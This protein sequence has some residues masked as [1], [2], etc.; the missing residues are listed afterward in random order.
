MQHR[1]VWLVVVA[2]CGGGSGAP[3]DAVLLPDAPL[4]TVIDAPLVTFVDA[5]PDSPPGG[6]CNALTQ[7][8]CSIGEKC[9]WISDQDN[10]PIGHVGCAPDP[11][12]SGI[13]IGSPCT[14]PPAGPM[15]YDNCVR[16]SVCLAGICKQICDLQNGAPTCDQNHACTRYADFFEVG[17]TAV[18]GVCDPGCDPLTQS[19]LAGASPLACGSVDPSMP[20]R[21]C[22]GY[23]NYSCSPAGMS[24]YTLT[25]R[26]PPRTNASGN[27]Y[28]N[29]CAPGF[30][31][32]FF[33]AT[34]STITLC[35]GYC[36]ALE[37]DNTPAHVG[38]SKGNAS[39]LAKLPTAPAPIAGD[40]TCDIG[41]KGSHASSMCK[42]IWPY[43]TDATTGMLPP[44]FANGPLLDT[45]GVCQAL[46]FF[47][48]DS[49]GDLTP[50]TPFP[51][52]S[53]LPP[54]V[55]GDLGQF[56]D[57]ADWGCQKYS[58][59][60]ILSTAKIRNPALDDIRIGG[61][62]PVPLLRHTFQ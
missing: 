44:Q 47:Q 58:N 3:A 37:I 27:P 39:A 17:G 41:K 24:V 11:A 57:A 19:L 48:Y 53:T 4:V 26:M 1:W 38:N 42:F 56:N 30:I 45:L 40:G 59:S 51:D 25:D 31:P 28:L 61:G 43:V 18:A 34:G 54:R 8:G 29:G 62:S 32:F 13:A 36:A 23:D 22:Y 10:P 9:T 6:P 60:Q 49:N 5:S 2:A 46:A 16:G 20:T 35:T 21:G 12:A 50:D 33:A 7:L 52:C 15:G 14:D 55:P